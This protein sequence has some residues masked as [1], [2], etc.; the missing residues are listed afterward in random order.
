MSA[1]H[2]SMRRFGIVL[3]GVAVDGGVDIIRSEEQ[4][5]RKADRCAGK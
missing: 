5:R 3:D 2:Q 1:T 4:G